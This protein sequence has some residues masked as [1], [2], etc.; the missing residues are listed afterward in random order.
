M[1]SSARTL[2]L[3][4][5]LVTMLVTVLGTGCGP[6]G[7]DRGFYQPDMTWGPAS[8]SLYN[9]DVDWVEQYCEHVHVTCLEEPGYYD[10]CLEDW[11]YYEQL[12]PKDVAA[13]LSCLDALYDCGDQSSWEWWEMVTLACASEIHLYEL[14]IEPYMQWD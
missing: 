7:G 10:Y 2:V 9:P 12:C 4:T 8:S 6:S 3:V 13:L 1:C 5:V 11:R 14:C